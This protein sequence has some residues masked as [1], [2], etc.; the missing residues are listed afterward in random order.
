[1]T[2]AIVT[3]MLLGYLL[4]CTEHITRI[5]KATVAL[6]CGVWG[7]VL[8]VCV[9]PYYIETLHDA[10]FQEF[11][12]NEDY[13]IRAV[14]EF[15]RQKVFASHIAQLTSVVMY[16]LTTMAIVDVLANNGCFDLVTKLCRSRST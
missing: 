8:Y 12:G 9:G 15:I 6:F 11:L 2:I 10:G 14:N 13:S 16:L 5:N 7:W 4:I 3:L 1:M